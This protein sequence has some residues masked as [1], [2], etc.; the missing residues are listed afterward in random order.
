MGS[1]GVLGQVI[2]DLAC[3][4]YDFYAVTA[5]LS[6]ASGFDR[7]EKSFPDKLVNVGIAEQN[8]I[9]VAAG[10]AASGTPVVATTWA[11]F[12]SSRVADQVRNYMGY[13]QRNIKLIGMDSG[14]VQSRF[15]YS[16][17]NPPDI[18]IMRTIPG[19][20]ILSPCDG[21]EIYSAIYA[22]LK[23]DGPVYIRLTGDTTLPIVHRE[24]EFKYEIGKSIVLQE[25]KK[26]A[27]LATGNVVRNA[28]EAAQILK[29]KKLDIT[30]ADVHTICPIDTKLLNELISYDLVVTVEEHMIQGGFGS[31]VAEFYA[32]QKKR[33]QVVL[34]GVDN[35]F[36]VSG[37]VQFEHNCFGLLPEQIADIIMRINS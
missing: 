3:E 7:L 25:G 1:R 20:T 33:P 37:S 13:M 16:H 24:N 8:L 12:A 22:A 17:T 35:Q 6:H 15:S 28:I 4:G 21:V 30:V 19:I 2:Y 31:S 29:E 34:L 26:I 5:D 10:L 27:I 11:M 9:G 23:I 14:F 36:T 18:A 32:K